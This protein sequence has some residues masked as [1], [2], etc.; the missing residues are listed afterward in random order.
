MENEMAKLA[1]DLNI[2]VRG[3]ICPMPVLK[4]KK[5]LDSLRPGQV[6]EVMYSD[7]G[8]KTDLLGLINRMGHELIKSTDEADSCCFF[9]K[10]N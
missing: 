3:L 8:T 5:A 9:I 6:L 7:A 4:T 2:D 10:K 1:S